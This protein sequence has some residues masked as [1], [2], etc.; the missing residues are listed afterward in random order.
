MT[1]GHDLSQGHDAPYD[2]RAAVRRI[3]TV[4]GIGAGSVALP[5]LTGTADAKAGD[6]MRVGAKNAAGDAQTSLSGA[7]TVPTL[8]I[9]NT[10]SKSGLV[11]DQVDLISP[12]L[13]LS[14][15]VPSAN[16][17]QIPDVR[18]FPAGAIG[19][20]GG[21]MMLG[22]DLGLEK[23]APVQ[24][25]TSAISNLLVPIPPANATVFDTTAMTPE[26][27]AALPANAFDASGRVA[28]GTRVPIGLRALINSEKFS[29]SAAAC[30]SVT[31]AGG[32]FSGAVNVHASADLPGDVTI[33]SYAVLP[34][35]ATANGQPLALAATGSAVVAL[36]NV[37]QLWI[38][39][40][41]ATHLKVQVTAVVVPDPSVLVEPEHPIEGLSPAARR[42]ALQRQALR[43]MNAGQPAAK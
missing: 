13:Q 37:D 20:A 32:D 6:A 16:R 1:D 17:P 43:E 35:E 5:S 33:V 34:K 9:E 23:P 19:I 42:G 22:A 24:V 25:H 21:A 30:V 41:T 12:Q 40:T 15:S 38:S 39:T 2:R 14:T 28:P 10:R 4:M 31:A 26:Q 8:K 29:Q 3:A 7:G 36:D 27:R 11:E 18:S